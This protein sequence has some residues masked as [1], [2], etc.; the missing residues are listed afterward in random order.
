MVV[1]TSPVTEELPHR[2][3]SLSRAARA[4][5]AIPDAYTRHLPCA[6]GIRLGLAGI[7]GNSAGRHRDCRVASHG[8]PPPPASSTG[9]STT[10]ASLSPTAS[11][12]AC[13]TPNTSEVSAAELTPRGW[14]LFLVTSGDFNL[15]IA[16]THT[17]T[18][19]DR[20]PDDLR[21][22]LHKI[23]PPSGAH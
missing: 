1:D 8:R 9:S 7:V 17:V 18:A 20:L 2:P 6:N 10:P 15:A 16:L 11:R 5:K 21:Q 19:V 23:T 12:S 13:A 14:G 22:A 3:G 4:D